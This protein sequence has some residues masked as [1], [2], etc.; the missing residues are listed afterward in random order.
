MIKEVVVLLSEEMCFCDVTKSIGYETQ[1]KA[2][3]WVLIC[4]HCKTQL[5]IPVEGNT[6]VKILRSDGTMRAPNLANSPTFSIPPPVQD[7]W[8]HRTHLCFL[9][10]RLRDDDHG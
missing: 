6:H 2:Q 4:P 5:T 3:Y 10:R 8:R 1:R 9:P 7:T